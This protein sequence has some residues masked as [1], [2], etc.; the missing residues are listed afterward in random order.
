MGRIAY[1]ANAPSPS[2]PFI[3]REAH[4]AC[5]YN[6]QTGEGY[7]RT[8]CKH[9]RHSPDVCLI[10]KNKMGPAQTSQRIIAKVK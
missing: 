2:T 8:R 5:V 4:M 7:G 9:T 10:G 6:Q 1:T 3:L